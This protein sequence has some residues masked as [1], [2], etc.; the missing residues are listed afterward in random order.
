MKKRKSKNILLLIF[1]LTIFI[2]SIILFNNSMANKV[3]KINAEISDNDGL[4][5]NETLELSATEEEN[6]SYSIILPE[7]INGKKVSEYT[8]EEALINEEDSSGILE[9]EAK[10]NTENNNNEIK[11]ETVKESNDEELS[12]KETVVESSKKPGDKIYLSNEQ[13]ENKEIE[14]VVKYDSKKVE[15]T[16]LYNKILEKEKDNRNIKLEGYMPVNSTFVVEEIDAESINQELD[17]F[18]IK[19]ISLKVAYDIQIKDG[20]QE[21][22]PNDY[23]ENIQ[24]T[25]TNIKES[26]DN[27]YRVVH[28]DSETAEEVTS[29]KEEGNDIL[30]DA[31]SFSVYAVL[32]DVNSELT[33]YSASTASVREIK[34]DG[35]ISSGFE[36]GNGSEESPYLITT[37]EELAYLAETVNNGTNYSGQYF[38]LINDIDLNNIEWTPIGNTSN[39]FRGIFD[40]AGHIISNV[41]I[42]TNSTP[43]SIE[44]YGIFGTIGGGAQRAVIKNLEI[45]N[46]SVSLGGSSRGQNRRMACRNTCRNNV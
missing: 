45:D 29:V 1:L 46:V 30:F 13:V 42:S 15:D 6:N 43:S 39:S 7:D 16:I 5:D 23:E 35:T 36:Y 18:L 22:N 44:S 38:Q 2:I 3:I 19:N 41:T 20:E 26:D 25:I 31:E 14:I 10:E 34:W 24:V 11:L 9:D 33:T 28:I 17:P 4:L 32:E 40:G 21:Y 27:E 37:G 8:V 12:R